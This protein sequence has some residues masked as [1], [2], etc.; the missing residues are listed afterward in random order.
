VTTTLEHHLRTASLRD[1]RKAI[2]DR[3][4]RRNPVPGR[5]DDSIPIGGGGGA[6]YSPLTIPDLLYF[7]RYD[8]A[9]PTNPVSGAASTRNVT[10]T[11]PNMTIALG[12]SGILDVYNG[13][14]VKCRGYN[15]AG[16]NGD[17]DIVLANTGAV[18]IVN[19]AAVPEIGPVTSTVDVVGLCTTAV[20]QVHGLAFT[21]ATVND[22]FSINTSH[23]GNGKQCI[24]QG[25]GTDITRLMAVTDAGVLGALNG[26]GDVT[27]FAYAN[28]TE[29]VS[30]FYP[31]GVDDGAALQNRVRGGI[32]A[33]NYIVQQQGSGL[34]TSQNVP[35]APALNTWQLTAWIYSGPNVGTIV[36]NGAT[37]GSVA[38]SVQRTRVNLERA[39]VS[40]L[41]NGASGAGGSRGFR[42]VDG[43]V[44]RAMALAELVELY[45]WCTELST[46]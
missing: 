9:A 32:S 40:N 8:T 11:P 14:T 21:Q 37:V 34:V 41:S 4:L 46:P 23:I 15:N 31:V 26:V 42:L 45:D 7:L 25:L 13:G 29:L 5:T 44:A 28:I 22:R 16:N 19:P 12:G 20:D 17:F 18:T 2:R 3:A 43:C 24:S 35:G 1:V 10:G 30:T 6:P 36:V 38:N 39:L 33:P 27:F